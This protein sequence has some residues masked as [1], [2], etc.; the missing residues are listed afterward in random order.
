[1]K[2]ARA[3]KCFSKYLSFREQFDIAADTTAAIMYMHHLRPQPIVHCD[4]RATNVMITRDMVAKVSDLGASRI[5]NSSTSL[6]AL[7]Y[8]YCA[9]KKM[10]RSDGSSA[11]S[12]RES[13]IYSLGVMLTESFTG[14]SPDPSERQNQIWKIVNPDLFELCLQMT[15][16]ILT[17]RPSAENVLTSFT[18]QKSTDQYRSILGR[19]IV[20]FEAVQVLLFTGT[21]LFTWTILFIFAPILFIF[22]SILFIFAPI[23]FTG[24]ILFTQF[25]PTLA[26]TILFTGDYPVHVTG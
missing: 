25:E 4:I 20:W 2:A 6:G 5:I 10:P 18:K 14:L 9:P 15:W 23:L 19:R 16:S 26:E 11:H 7:S 22:A 1:M 21:I 24:T 8:E 3:S 17:E 13:G 12:T